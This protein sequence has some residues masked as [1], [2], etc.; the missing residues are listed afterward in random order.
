L[1]LFIGKLRDRASL[2]AAEVFRTKRKDKNIS[3]L[4]LSLPSGISIY[5]TSSAWINETRYFRFANKPQPFPFS[6]ILFAMKD[7]AAFRL[8]F[9]RF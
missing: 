9:L 4:N 8:K 5:I 1:G 6:T 7:A 2:R 3:E